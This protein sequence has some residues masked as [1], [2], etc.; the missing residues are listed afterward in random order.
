[1]KIQQ[2]Q[3]DSL[4]ESASMSTYILHWVIF[5]VWMCQ[6]V[7]A[8]ILPPTF[9][10]LILKWYIFIN[11]MLSV[12]RFECYNFFASLLDLF[13]E[14]FHSLLMLFFLKVLH[15]MFFPLIIHLCR[16]QQTAVRSLIDS[17]VLLQL[18]NRFYFSQIQGFWGSILLFE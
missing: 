2:C 8:A 15:L 13:P 5:H 4:F 17:C 12:V 3:Q 10:I 1:M 14:L 6:I 11:I 18:F 7:L 9:C 16:N